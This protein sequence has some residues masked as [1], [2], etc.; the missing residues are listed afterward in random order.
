M[1]PLSLRML[2]NEI[3]EFTLTKKEIVKTINGKRYTA[4][5]RRVWLR[6]VNILAHK[7]VNVI[8]KQSKDA[9]KLDLSL[10]EENLV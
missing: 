8:W 4:N 5:S 7:I 1:Y 2:E 10:S 9:H 6:M 3:T